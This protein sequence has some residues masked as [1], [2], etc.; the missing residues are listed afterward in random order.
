MPRSMCVFDSSIGPPTSRLSRCASSCAFVLLPNESLRQRSLH[1]GLCRVEVAIPASRALFLFV[2]L[3]INVIWILKLS[4]PF[5]AKLTEMRPIVLFAVAHVLNHFKVRLSTEVFHFNL[6][7]P[8]EITASPGAF[9][10]FF[11]NLYSFLESLV[12]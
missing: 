10:Q 8:Q 1:E 4:V 2:R 5:A 9:L 3:E 11:E 6:K 12:K 7:R